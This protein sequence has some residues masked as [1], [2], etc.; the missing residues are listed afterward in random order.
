VTDFPLTW[1]QRNRLANEFSLLAG[2][3]DIWRQTGTT[4]AL[5]V[6][7]DYARGLAAGLSIAANQ[8]ARDLDRLTEATPSCA[9]DKPITARCKECVL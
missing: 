4:T 1:T 9:H 5:E 7:N 8:L 6:N 2:L 3:P